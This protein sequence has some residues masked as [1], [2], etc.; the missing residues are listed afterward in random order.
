MPP[1]ASPILSPAAFNQQMEAEPLN[2]LLKT[3]EESLTK[4]LQRVRGDP[5]S[6]LIFQTL[7]WS[8][9]RWAIHYLMSADYTASMHDFIWDS[10]ID[11]VREFAPD[12][13]KDFAVVW[14][15]PSNVGDRIDILQELNA[16]FMF[17]VDKLDYAI[18]EDNDDE[19]DTLS[20]FLDEKIT[21]ILEKWLEGRQEYSIYP[22]INDSQDSFP[23]DKIFTIMQRILEKHVP[24]PVEEPP[25]K[26]VVEVPQV[27]NP[28]VKVPPPAPQEPP[29]PPQPAAPPKET[30]RSALRKRTLRVKRQTTVKSTRKAK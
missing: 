8:F 9:R 16:Y 30:V 13:L 26:E 19:Q 10:H 4:L 12:G 22:S 3:L 25:V 2:D 6:L 17:I 29:S 5:W 15:N 7:I 20:N 11:L 24:K 14:L 23:T 1:D 21:E 28:P 27:E 18:Q